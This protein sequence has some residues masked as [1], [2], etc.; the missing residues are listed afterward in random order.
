MADEDE[1]KSV[2][3]KRLVGRRF[4]DSKSHYK[5]EGDKVVVRYAAFED[6]RPGGVS[7]DVLWTTQPEPAAAA[8][9]TQ[10]KS[11]KQT[12]VSEGFP[13]HGWACF[14]AEKL[15]QGAKSVVSRVVHSETA[16]NSNHAHL[17]S[18]S[19]VTLVEPDDGQNNFRAEAT[20]KILADFHA[21]HGV[22]HMAPTIDVD[23]KQ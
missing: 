19:F 15:L 13:V 7:L 14:Q 12:A 8:K 16:T 22:T 2:D 10:L 1:L 23:Q 4:K 11:A 17:V 20:A 21:S 6:R 9:Q 3:G 5:T 18:N